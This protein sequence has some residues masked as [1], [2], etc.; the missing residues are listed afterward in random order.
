MYKNRLQTQTHAKTV[1]WFFDKDPKTFIEKK[2][3]I[4]YDGSEKPRY[5]HPEEWSYTLMFQHD[6]I[7]LQMDQGSLHKSRYYKITRR[8]SSEYTS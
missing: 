6:K 8:K 4:F 3:G 1:T 2:T 7:Q 5:Q